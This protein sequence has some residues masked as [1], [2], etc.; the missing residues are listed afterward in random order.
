MPKPPAPRIALLGGTALAL[1]LA[2][3]LPAQAFDAIKNQVREHALSNGMKWI[4]LE[5]HEAPVVGYHVYADVGSANEVSGIT[6]LSHLLE[7]MAF[8][9]SR[10]VGTKD[11]AAESVVLDRLDSLYALIRTAEDVVEP[12]TVRLAGL[13][14]TFE[15]TRLQ[16]QQYVV[17][18]E[19]F[20]L[21][22]K[23]GDQGVNA[24][25]S[26][27]ATQY[28]NSQPSNRLEFWMALTSD[29]FLNPVFREFYKERDVV[30]EER[31]L[32]LETR[33]IGKL[34]EDFLAVS[35]KC[36]PY[37][38][39]VVGD[40]SDLRRITH[41]DVVDY[42]RKYYSPSNLV[43]AV[44]GD[45][46]ADAVFTMAELYF[47]RIPSGPKPE[48]VRTEEPEQWGERHVQV[49]AK[50]E[51]LVIVGYHKPSA[52][53]KD[54]QAFDA[55]ANIIGQGRSSRIYRTLV[56]EQKVAIDAGFFNGWPGGKYPNLC[57]FY[58]LTAQGKSVAECLA[59]VDAEIERI[60]TEPVTADELAKYKRQTTK[61]LIDQMK[62]NAQM[63]SL[64]TN[65]EVIQGDWRDLFDQIQRVQSITAADVQR[66]AQATL[67][68]R[69]R[70]VGELVPEPAAAA[71]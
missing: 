62:G 16:A 53:S 33:P 42:F 45:V 34:I 49:E 51:P 39:A 55:M 56:K 68:R 21:C 28:I 65:Y 2:A 35:F 9:G 5:R 64:L 24:Y 44:V 20:D 46:D 26:N 19:Y 60:R 41:Q 69:N 59:L 10:T 18:N 54:D 15:E 17:N 50:S 6:G 40:M 1:L 36:H 30:M 23:E 63:A 7:H 25:T 22:M 11:Y 37:R 43:A 8:K 70:T 29:R 32:S 48:A 71:Q 57:A 61:S 31:R 3:P 52:R 38:H 12:D 67:V 66:V 4:V 47:G 14:K 27:D 58:A 13:R